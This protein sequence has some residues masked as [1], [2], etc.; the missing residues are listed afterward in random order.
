MHNTFCI[1]LSNMLNSTV[2][3][4][5]QCKCNFPQISLQYM[6]FH[7]STLL[8]HCLCHIFLQYTSACPRCIDCSTLLSVMR[9]CTTLSTMH[10]YFLL[11]I[12]V[13][14]SAIQ[15]ITVQYSASECN[16]VQYNA[17]ACNV[18]RISGLTGP[19]SAFQHTPNH[20]HIP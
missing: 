8:P 19:R 7:Y 13:L 11:C 6:S 10:Y 20:H 9:F 16:T 12:T 5:L 18:G 1:V 2:H 14:Y 15:C 4:A 17:P 3:C